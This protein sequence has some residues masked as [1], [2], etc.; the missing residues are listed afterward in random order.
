MP[1]IAQ[2]VADDVGLGKTIE[3]VLVIQELLL[4]HRARQVLVVCPPKLTLKWRDGMRDK[5]RSRSPSRTARR[6]RSCAA[7][8]DSRLTR[9]PCTP[10]MITSL[11]WRRTPRVQRLLD[12]VLDAPSRHPGFID[13]MV[14]DEAHHVAPPAP[15]KGRNGYAVDSL[16]ADSLQTVRCAGCA[17]TA[18]T[19]S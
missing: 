16:Q 14:V 5:F 11:P 12:D 9:S 19:G 8:T 13:L 2:L 10:R 17:S 4:R 18:S 1:R 7:A 15:S 6:S 3:A